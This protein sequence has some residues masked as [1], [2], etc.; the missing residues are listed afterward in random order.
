MAGNAPDSIPVEQFKP[1]VAP[2]QAPQ[3]AAQA[4]PDAI[5]VSQFKPDQ[6][7]PQ[8]GPPDAIPVG[9][10][11]S[12]EDTYGSGLQQIQTGAEGLLRGASFG[13]SD[14]ILSHLLNAPGQSPAKLAE[15]MR[16]R[17]ETNPWISGGTGF[18]G[19]TAALIGSGGIAPALEKAG[20]S[21]IPAMAA[22]GGVF[23]AGNAVSDIALTD[24]NLQ[25]DPSL[26]A[27][28]VIAHTLM[29]TVLGAGLGTLAKVVPVAWK[30]LKGKSAQEAVNAMDSAGPIIDTQPKGPINS[31]EE[32]NKRNAYD[33]AK[34]EFVEA[35]EKASLQESVSRLQ[36][37]EHPPLPQ[38]VESLGSPQDRTAYKVL[39]E[40]DTEMGRDVTNYEARQK[41]ELTNKTDEVISKLGS[42]K[43]VTDAAKAGEEA[44]QSFTDNYQ[45][46]Q[47]ALTPVFNALKKFDI[48]D[49]HLNDQD[50][51]EKM[52]EKVPGINRMFKI[53]TNR[54][55]LG[56]IV[57][58]KPYDAKWGIDK[59]T[60]NA[61]K[62]VQK[63]MSGL[64]DETATLH[65]LLNIRK[66]LDQ[67]V[68]VMAQGQAA[69]EIR[70]LKGVMMDYAQEA[71]D[72]IVK[73][74]EEFK[75]PKDIDLGTIR[76]TF[77]RYAIN[78]QQ[79]EV[80]EKVFGASVGKTEF[81]QISKIKPENILDN[82]FKNTATVKA[83][84]QILD[85]PQFD[86]MLANHLAEKRALATLDGN[87]S[88]AKFGTFLR[89]NQD[90]LNE[91]FQP[92][93][94]LSNNLSKVSAVRGPAQLQRL[95][96]LNRLS[97]ILPDAVSVNPSGTA[98]TIMKMFEN[99]ANPVDMMLGLA[100]WKALAGKKA[101]EIGRQYV[102]ERAARN[103][104]ANGFKGTIPGRASGV[105]KLQSISGKINV[106]NKQLDDAAS[107]IFE[108]SDKK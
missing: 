53:D 6:H 71:L 89:N 75:I 93:F 67:H 36:D 56:D 58:V 54:S 1:D 85:A 8:S 31:M 55:N 105:E 97:R 90:S 87:F 84:K 35:P 25:G 59:A 100:H 28:K 108:R 14:P 106:V 38:Q 47:K 95:N 102:K 99:S 72:I 11:K 42:G 63:S 101:Y 10:F 69:G 79:R 4:V 65:D 3:P 78:E 43:V 103:A 81:G 37:L 9:Q 32:F 80:I 88:S 29:G 91:A 52:G 96:D 45:N 50:L 60:Y 20:M 24:P 57:G 86:A 23:G 33:I 104:F 26:I 12:D 68:D 44:V 62:E 51:M 48:S 22:E 61:V 73:H 17:K 70:A 7:A 49:L 64:N 18:A 74:P 107:A 21:F 94:D 92:H 39:R 41:N 82:I 76:D 2:I 66:G 77:K 83:A 19:S 40:S 46:E 30:G 34:G 13:L 98:K 5:P 15:D 16:L 27:Q